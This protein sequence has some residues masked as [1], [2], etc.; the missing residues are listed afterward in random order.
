MEKVYRGSL[1]REQFLFYEIRVVAKLLYQGENEEEIRKKIY[2]NNLFQLPT[3]KSISTITTACYKRLTKAG[4]E[5]LIDI[6]ANESN[7]VAKQAALYL[8]MRYNAIV[9]DFMVEVIGTKYKTRDFSFDKSEV[10]HF[11][12]NLRT[13]NDEASEWTDATINKI[14]SVLIKIL[15]DT[16]LLKLSLYVMKNLFSP[17]LSSFAFLLIP[18]P[19]RSR[20][21]SR[22]RFDFFSFL[23]KFSPLKT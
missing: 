9:W 11:L 16:I 6:I 23:F 12:S 8:L 5:R 10:N 17:G 22:K 18:L 2:D 13:E 1:T 21:K 4:N 14:R 3:E 7:E 19:S 20:L 15:S